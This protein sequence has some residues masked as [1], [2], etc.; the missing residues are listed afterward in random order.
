MYNYGTTQ[1]TTVFF[2]KI[3][4]YLHWWLPVRS[5]RDRVGQD[6]SGVDPCIEGSAQNVKKHCFLSSLTLITNKL[7]RSSLESLLS[8]A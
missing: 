5:S 3:V 8:L 6:E 4:N 1:I 7:E 2:C